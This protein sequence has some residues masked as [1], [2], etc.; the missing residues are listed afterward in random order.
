MSKIN[1]KKLAQIIQ[2][3]LTKALEEDA[4]VSPDATQQNMYRKNTEKINQAHVCS[5]CGHNVIKLG[6]ECNECGYAEPISVL[7]EDCGCGTCD[8][9]GDDSVV[10]FKH[11]SG[12]KQ[13]GAYMSK[14]QLYKIANYAQKLYYTIPDNHNLQDWMRTKLAQISDD[15]SEVYHALDHDIFEGDI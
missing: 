3:E 13:E 2:E 4:L 7:K 10:L 12:G 11:H 5:Q 9:C 8:E 6:D 15:I 14:S 1:R